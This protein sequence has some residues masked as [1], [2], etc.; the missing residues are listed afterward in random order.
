MKKTATLVAG[1]LLVTGTV[2]ATG[3]NGWDLTGTTVEGDLWLMHSENGPLTSDGGD[4][5]VTVEAT[6]ETEVGK[7]G[8]KAYMEDANDGDDEVT[9][10]FSRTQ[11]NFEV[12]LGAAIIDRADGAEEAQFRLETKDNSD[13]Y[14]KWNMTEKMSL[15]YYPWEVDGMSSFDEDTFEA[16]VI[17]DRSNDYVEAKGGL[18]LAINVN[19][20]TTAT[21]KYAVLSPGY[22]DNKENFFAYK[23]E[24]KTKVGPASVDAYVAYTTGFATGMKTGSTTDIDAKNMYALGARA[25]MDLNEKVSL[26]AEFNMENIE[27]AKYNDGTLNGKDAETAMGLF[28]KGAMKLADMAEYKPTAYASFKYLNDV[29]A[30]RYDEG[31]TFNDYMELEAGLTLAQ[32]NFSVTPKVVIS[33]Q[34][35]EGAGTLKEGFAEYDGTGKEDMLYKVGVNFKYAL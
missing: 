6:K 5:D 3:L 1:L 27:D 26:T 35:T 24:L 12:G 29:A 18:A 32:G 17:G 11:G 31:N 9:L 14:L 16:F 13:S 22:E 20:D 4:L 33:M 21:L 10:S 8:V 28:V 15:T 2:L 34:D 7:F 30:D 19:A 25:L 23:G